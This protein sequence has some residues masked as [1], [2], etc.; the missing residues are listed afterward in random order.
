MDSET[1]GQ[2][3][4][5]DMCTS[6]LIAVAAGHARYSSDFCV[7]NLPSVRFFKRKA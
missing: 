6:V 5:H 2:D 4:L 1:N 7:F 3:S